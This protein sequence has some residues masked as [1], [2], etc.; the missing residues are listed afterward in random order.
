MVT[1]ET[2]N[3]LDLPV[4]VPIIRMCDRDRDP[5]DLQSLAMQQ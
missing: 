4:C 1:V 2:T 5:R 3:V